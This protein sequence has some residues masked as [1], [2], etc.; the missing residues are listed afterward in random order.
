MLEVH[1]IVWL[2]PARTALAG[3]Y[4]TAGRQTGVVVSAILDALRLINEAKVFA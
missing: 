4:A 1:P 3:D 2:W